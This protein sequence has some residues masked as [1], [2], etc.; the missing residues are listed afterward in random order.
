LSKVTELLNSKYERKQRVLVGVV[1]SV[2]M[3]ADGRNTGKI[4]A[5][6]AGQAGITVNIGSTDVY[7]VGDTIRVRSTGPV[8]QSEYSADGIVAAV[9][10]SSGII[11]YPSDVTIGTRTFGEGDATL[12]DATGSHFWFD[13]ST[14]NLFMMK[15][16]YQRGVISSDGYLELGNRGYSWSRY[17]DTATEWYYGDELISAIDGAGRTIYGFERW[18]RP[19]GPAIEI[20]EILDVDENGDP[21]LNTDGEQQKRYGVICLDHSGA[22]VWSL[23]TGTETSP[24]TPAFF[25]G[26]P[27]DAQR[28]NWEDGVLNV[29]GHVYM[30]SGEIQGVLTIGVDG[31]IYQGTGTFASPT[32]GLKIWNSS[33][34]GRFASYSSGVVQAYVDT[35]GKLKWAGGNAYMSADGIV[36]SVGTSRTIATPF[37]GFGTYDNIIQSSS[38]D[39]SGWAATDCTITI[40]DSESP[41]L[42]ITADKIVFSASTGELQSG[43]PLWTAFSYLPLTLTFSVWLKA[44]ANG[45]AHIGIFD[46]TTPTSQLVNVTTAWQRFSAP[47]TF[48]DVNGSEYGCRIIRE[49][50]DVDTLWAW[51]AQLEEASAMGNYV[52]CDWDKY[53]N[54]PSGRGL[55][56]RGEPAGQFTGDSYGILTSGSYAGISSYGGNVGGAFTTVVNGGIGISA[57]TQSASDVAIS[58]GTGYFNANSNRLRY[59]GAATSGMD[60]LNRDTADARYTM[61]SASDSGYLLASGSIVGATASPQTFTNGIIAPSWQ[62][63]T[64]SSSAIRVYS[65]SGSTIININSAS[66]KVNIYGSLQTTRFYT[67][68]ARVYTV[69]AASSGDYITINEAIVA[70]NAASNAAAS[71][72]YHISVQSGTYTEDVNLPDY[73]SLAGQ[74]WKSTTISGSLVANSSNHIE[75]IT[76]YNPSPGI[77]S[78]ISK[79]VND[80]TYFTNTYI[81]VNTSVNGPTYAI[82]HSGSGGD[83]RFYNSF[84]YARNPNTGASAKTYIIKHDGTTGDAEVMECHLKNSNPSASGNILA[85]NTSTGNGGDIIV[86]NSSWSVFSNASAMGAINE[87]ASGQIKL[88]IDYENDTS[89][90]SVYDVSGSGIVNKVALPTTGIYTGATDYAQAFTKGVTT[91][92][93]I[94]INTACPIYMLDIDGLTSSSVLRVSSNGSPMLH[95]N[96]YGLG[97]GATSPSNTDDFVHIERNSA[98]SP[99]GILIYN[100]TEDVNSDAFVHLF[101]GIPASGGADLRMSVAPGIRGGFVNL[102]AQNNTAFNILQNASAP[103]YFYTSGLSR[104][105]IN[106][107]G[108]MTLGD[109][110]GRN[111][112]WSFIVQN[113]STGSLA[114]AVLQAKTSTTYFSTNVY[115]A[116]AGAYVN[117]QATAAT[118]G[119]NILQAASS[120]IA[121]YTSNVARMRIDA[122]G[123]LG[124]GTTSP[125]SYMDVEAGNIQTGSLYGYYIGSPSANGSWYTAV[126][127][128]AL[129]NQYR[130]SGS[131]FTGLKTTYNGIEVKSLIVALATQASNYTLAASDHVLLANGASTISLPTASN[132][133]GRIYHIKNVSASIVVVSASNSETIDGSATVSLSS[134]YDKLQIISNGA[135]WSIL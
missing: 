79:P 98:G 92:C 117:L 31:G 22:A 114:R 10:P 28:L 108:N 30:L 77:V 43:G 135:N 54:Q 48:T 110:T 128:S 129:L 61:P 94:G 51:G 62:A 109:A 102:T 116:G 40:N 91:S 123:R 9:R 112:D 93:P 6:V 120:F 84:I 26:R 27:E 63:I 83:S 18:G 23:L 74:S 4:V 57:T 55:V 69:D 132:I 29:Y 88:E 113:V 104:A 20:K 131:L 7:Y 67:P 33:G 87:S 16:D 78:V 66:P 101:A 8:T 15:G 73:V 72:P 121:F 1:T 71:A 58:M 60:A 82:Q 35:D 99:T 34:I 80:T 38:E 36:Q 96:Q 126:T 85:W 59:V 25:F 37:G 52:R 103:I 95:L 118:G 17:T 68:Y 105:N 64:D 133:S 65:S 39:L 90:T 89:D 5:T 46:T 97:I 86:L 19:H 41:D 47:C 111:T 122:S 106:A 119:L 13:Y 76:I 49:S 2:P 32:T 124:I 115:G 125:S 11:E 24:T 75:N 44:S 45:T 12:G 14:G 130:S 53:A 127:A 81:V 21:I 3:R 42:S 134:Q 56:A 70:I 100:R 50:G 107:S